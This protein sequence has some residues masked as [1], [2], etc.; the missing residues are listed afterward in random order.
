MWFFG[1]L[2]SER[3]PQARTA[4]KRRMSGLAASER[5]EQQRLAPAKRGAVGLL[6]R[7]SGGEGLAIPH[8]LAR[9]DSDVCRECISVF[10]A[11]TAAHG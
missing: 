6:R 3:R 10:L 8:L 7:C 5:F 9:S 2:T 11:A 4:A 1:F